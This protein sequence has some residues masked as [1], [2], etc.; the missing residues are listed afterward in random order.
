MASIHS[1][2]GVR[3]RSARGLTRHMPPQYHHSTT[4]RAELDL[5]ALRSTDYAQVSLVR[6][7][8]SFVSPPV[9]RVESDRSRFSSA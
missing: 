6:D 7:I 9:R 2:T 3:R 4:A 5:C 1:A 8:L